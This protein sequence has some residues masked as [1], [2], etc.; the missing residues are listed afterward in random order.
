MAVYDAAYKLFDGKIDLDYPD[1]YSITGTISHKGAPKEWKERELFDDM[2][3]IEDFE[4]KVADKLVEE[5]NT[6][7]FKHM[8]GNSLKKTKNGL[9]IV[10]A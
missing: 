1:S 10:E 3:R 2:P 6:P 8:F 9:K 4:N 7:V 5:S